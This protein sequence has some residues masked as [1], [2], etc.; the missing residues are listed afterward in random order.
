MEW[1]DRVERAGEQVP[2][3]APQI[4]RRKPGY[5]RTVLKQRCPECGRGF[6]Y[7]HA[8]NMN[9]LCPACGSRFEREPGYFT[10]AIYIGILLALQPV[11]LLMYLLMRYLPDIP[12]QVSALLA[13]LGFIP[14]LPLTLRLSRVMWLGIGRNFSP[15]QYPG[16][17]PEPPIPPL[18]PEPADPS[19]EERREDRE[20]ETVEREERTPV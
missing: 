1:N 2:A 7:G 16:S 14:L 9:T 4:T 20:A 6:V 19:G 18:D 11:L 15:D 8:M 3:M 13:V 17:S 10:G 5:L 12:L